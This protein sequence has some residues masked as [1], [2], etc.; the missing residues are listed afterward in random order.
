[1][2]GTL[3]DL[4]V[5]IETLDKKKRRVVHRNQIKE[6]KDPQRYERQDT[7]TREVHKPFLI[8]NNGLPAMAAQ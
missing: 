6:V 3:S 2:I 8:D 1:M 7:T 5:R 4:V